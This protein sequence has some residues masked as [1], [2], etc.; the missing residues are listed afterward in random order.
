MARRPRKPTTAMVLAAGMGTRMRPLTDHVPK[1]LVEVA[2]ICLIDHVLD[3][4][5]AAGVETAVVNVHYRADQ[6]EHHLARRT[7]PRIVISDERDRLLETGG[8]V[9]RALHLLGPGP[10]FIC[11]SDSISHG[12]TGD[13]LAR[14]A[15]MW[16]EGCMDSLLLVA[17]ATAAI[18]Y[19]GTGDFAMTPDGVLRRRKEREVVPF[20]FTG[21]SLATARMFE[22]SP[23]GPFSLNVLWSRAIEAGRLHGLRQDGVWLHVGSPEAV[24]EAERCL[25]LG[26]NYF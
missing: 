14:M 17:A 6:M 2:G 3:R 10:F 15:A 22:D 1:P 18:G 8:G 5:A 21:L 26:E 4:L 11:N 16:D 7:A 19:E 12:G 23:D 24:M 13:N 20:V 9:K 25:A